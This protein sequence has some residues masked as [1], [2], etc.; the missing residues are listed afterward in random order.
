M[1]CTPPPTTPPVVAKT[2]ASIRTTTTTTTTTTSDDD[3]SSFPKQRTF[4]DYSTSLRKASVASVAL[5]GVSVALRQRSLGSCTPTTPSDSL[6][7]EVC[8]PS[9]PPGCACSRSS[10]N[11]EDDDD[12]DWTGLSGVVM[13]NGGED[14]WL[15]G[16]CFPGINPGMVASVVPTYEAARVPAKAGLSDNWGRFSADHR[17]AGHPIWGPESP[18]L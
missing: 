10:R 9:S 14:G 7:N 13:D 11:D 15:D 17:L 1:A 16:G 18:S 5:P 12:E 2:S 8:V 4:S 3:S 6:S